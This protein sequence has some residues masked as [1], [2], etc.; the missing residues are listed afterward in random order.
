VREAVEA[1][2]PRDCYVQKW[3]DVAV[4]FRLSDPIAFTFNHTCEQPGL[5]AGLIRL[6]RCCV[7]DVKQSEP[8]GATPPLRTTE[9]RQI[10]ALFV[11]DD[12]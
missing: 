3:T 4:T 8:G 12:P 1:A 9:P 7:V 2:K 6:A 10:G 11:G 5:R